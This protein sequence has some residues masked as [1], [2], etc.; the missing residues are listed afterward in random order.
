MLTRSVV[1]EMID[2]E[3]VGDEVEVPP[4]DGSWLID[5]RLNVG[6]QYI[7]WGLKL[8]KED[9]ECMPA[10][11]VRNFMRILLEGPHENATPEEIGQMVESQAGRK[12]VTQEML[13]AK[14]TL[15]PI[16]C[17]DHWTPIVLKNTAEGKVVEYRDSLK[18]ESAACRNY[19]SRFLQEMKELELPARC[20]AAMQPA[21]TGQCGSFVLHW[22]E[23]VCRNVCKNEVHSSA[24]WPTNEV[25][26]ARLKTLMKMLEK[27]QKKLKEDAKKQ[28]DKD[29]AKKE[30]E[31]KQEEKKKKAGKV[32][33]DVAV[34]ADAAT[35]ALKVMCFTMK[36]TDFEV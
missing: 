7:K 35:S 29:A 19:A 11:L 31:K 24:G 27:E 12:K 30:K 5:Q 32:K 4:E 21:K 15:V 23:Q 16:Y 8:Q 2:E 9:A 22:M 20:N 28:Q 14:L 13:K 34:L 1:T 17:S 18:V 33:D 26:G 36:I 25:W 6:W 10:D 3:V